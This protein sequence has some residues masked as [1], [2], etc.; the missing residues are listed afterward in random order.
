M[1]IPFNEI[2][3]GRKCFFILPDLSLMPEAYV[4]DFF[5]LGYEC[6]YIG[7]DGRT[8]IQKKID[9]ILKL[10][11]DVILFIN[12]DYEI[13]DLRWSEYL[14]ELITTKKA[15][16]EQI[17][18]MFSKRQSTVEK[19]N[20][21]QIFFKELELKRGY[22][23][24]EFQKKFN[25]ELIARALF[26]N[27]AQGRRKTIRA[28]CSNACTYK[29]TYGEKNDAISGSLQDISLSHFT[30]LMEDQPLPV[31]LYEKVQK[32]HFNIR[33][34]FFQSD[35]ILVMERK[36][37]ETSTLYVF[38]FV[39]SA[40]G[41]GVD[42]RTKETLVPV[43]Y[44][45]ISSNCLK[46]LE[47]EYRREDDPQPAQEEVAKEADKEENKVAEVKISAEQ[48]MDPEIAALGEEPEKEES[49]PQKEESE[50]KTEE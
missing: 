41:T 32:I 27:Q 9:S 19:E 21:E 35:A 4:Q 1:E 30:I 36:I 14:R 38:S 25:G 13:P 42:E 8:T 33:G 49:E 10:F 26:N 47:Q 7:N 12:I 17:G 28:L 2:V 45:M 5:A 43:L 31:K 50:E 15:T 37:S 34:S 22:I 40:G 6:Y 16:T 48:E 3:T 23:Q 24:L 20:I 46:L 29:F 39:T 44:S 18:I 11:K